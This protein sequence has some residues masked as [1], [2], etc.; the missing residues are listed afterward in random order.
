MS[1]QEV[2]KKATP[3]GKYLPL[4]KAGYDWLS[5]GVPQRAD[6]MSAG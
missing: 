2:L 4:M 1:M 3:Y 5:G 6:H